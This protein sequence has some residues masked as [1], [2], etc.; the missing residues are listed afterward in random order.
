MRLDK[1]GEYSNHADRIRR[2]LAKD[3]GDR[4]QRA[5]SAAFPD[6]AGGL[7]KRDL[8]AAFRQIEDIKRM[9]P[10]ENAPDWQVADYWRMRLRRMVD[11]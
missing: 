2:Q 7:A 8:V 4:F 9:V 11:R 1:A 10:D 6:R 3:V 5:V